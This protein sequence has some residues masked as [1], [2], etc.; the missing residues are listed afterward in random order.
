MQHAGLQ[1]YLSWLAS[2]N[3]ARAALGSCP[4]KT[5]PHPEETAEGQAP[6]KEK[7]S[8]SYELCWPEDKRAWPLR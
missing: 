3:L 1:G 2:C 8:G 4:Q 5:L 7:D 6:G